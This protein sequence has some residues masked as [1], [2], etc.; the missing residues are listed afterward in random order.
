MFSNQVKHFWVEHNK[1]PYFFNLFNYEYHNGL[2]V[3]PE[4]YDFDIKRKDLSKLDIEWFEENV[5]IPYPLW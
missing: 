5:L 1:T 3:D 2:F 4:G